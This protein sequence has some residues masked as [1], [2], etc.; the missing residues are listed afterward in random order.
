MATTTFY[1]PQGSYDWGYTGDA[2]TTIVSYFRGVS[3]LGPAI[4]SPAVAR[5]STDLLADDQVITGCVL[6]YNN[7][8]Y[9]ASV[10][11]AHLYGLWYNAGGESAQ[12]LLGGITYAS[13]WQSYT[14]TS[15]QCGWIDPTKESFITWSLAGPGNG[16]FR[17]YSIYAYE[18][19][20]T[21]SY[22]V[23]TH[24]DPATDVERV[25]VVM[26]G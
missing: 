2:N 18:S 5:Y 8:S 10:G 26:L 22:L 1:V 13:G 12:Q 4:V 6:H 23:I 17:T 24:V 16:K 9:S 21:K 3:K 19:G 14:F 7:Y 11:T 25:S 20:A 15:T